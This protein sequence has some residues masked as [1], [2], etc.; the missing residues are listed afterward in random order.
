[1]LYNHLKRSD[2]KEL[3]RH[4]VE[5]V[6]IDPEGTIRLEL[7]TP[8][9]YLRHV[10]ERV[11]NSGGGTVEGKQSASNSAGTCSDYVQSG[12]PEGIRTPDLYSAIVALSQL[13][14]RP[15]VILTLILRPH[16]APVKRQP[17]SVMPVSTSV[18]GIGSSS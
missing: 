7:R 17:H 10:T 2:Q 14:Y 4:M 15:V 16:P 18:N 6:I 12:G 8:F 5:R 9:A 11:Q 1:M 3:L 13:S